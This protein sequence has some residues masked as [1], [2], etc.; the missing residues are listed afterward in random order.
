MNCCELLLSHLQH[1]CLEM[2]FPEGGLVGS[3]YLLSLTH[4]SRLHPL[5]SPA[6]WHCWTE[7]L[8]SERQGSSEASSA[9][10]KVM[11]C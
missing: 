11:S 5:N 9:S 1:V 6:L 2:A 7:V 8:A 3:F 4:G 10:D